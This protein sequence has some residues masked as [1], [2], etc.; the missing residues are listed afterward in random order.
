VATARLGG[1][2]QTVL[3]QTRTV[4]V[5]TRPVSTPRN[6]LGTRSTLNRIPAGGGIPEQLLVIEDRSDVPNRNDQRLR[7]I[8]VSILQRNYG[9]WETVY[10][11]R[12]FRGWMRTW[13]GDLTRDGHLDVLVVSEQGT[14]GCGEHL[15]IAS[16][17]GQPREIY[18]RA[19][20]ET[21]HDL[22]GDRLVVNEPVGP[23]PDPEDALHCFG[24]RRVSVLRWTGTRLVRESGRVMCSTP[25][26]DPANECRRRR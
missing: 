18:R 20:C 21:W 1:D 7:G 4:T 17:R 23:C 13:L 24:G 14:A 19:T 3:T 11:R 16:V 15:V 25:K 22:R 26:L 10:D 12:F 2:R 5:T 9:F 6:R 8:Q